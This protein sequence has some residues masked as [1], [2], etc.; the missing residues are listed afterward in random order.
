MYINIEKTL[1][2][3]GRDL[4]KKKGPNIAEVKRAYAQT[5]R[6]QS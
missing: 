2:S 3:I 6:L 4:L 1:V 5:L